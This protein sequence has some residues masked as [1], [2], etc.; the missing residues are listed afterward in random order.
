M[1]ID[2]YIYIYIYTHTHTYTNLST[3]KQKSAMLLFDG[4]CNKTVFEYG[5]RRRRQVKTSAV[6]QEMAE[7]KKMCGCT[8]LCV[9]EGWAGV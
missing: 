3:L 2:I 9:G 7:K 5:R 4:V 8:C 6:L 1:Q